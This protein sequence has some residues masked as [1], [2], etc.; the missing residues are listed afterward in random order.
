MYLLFFTQYKDPRITQRVTKW[1]CS[2]GIKGEGKKCILWEY[3]RQIVVGSRLEEF[4]TV[5][6]RG[7]YFWESVPQSDSSVLFGFLCFIFNVIF[8]DLHFL[9][10]FASFAHHL[11]SSFIQIFHAN[12]NCVVLESL[13]C[14]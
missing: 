3:V 11:W 12:K 13:T 14:Y 8:S 10:G 9:E 7:I 2:K 1:S 4:N 5:V 6:I